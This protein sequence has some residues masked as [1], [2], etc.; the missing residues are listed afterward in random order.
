MDGAGVAAALDLGAVAAQL[1]TAFVARPEA[2]ADEAYRAALSGSSAYLSK[3]M[4]IN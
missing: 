3:G 2:G 4:S 1:G